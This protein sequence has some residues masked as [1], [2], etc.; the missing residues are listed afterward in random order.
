MI[1]NCNTV[2]NRINHMLNQCIK[3]F[4][5][6]FFIRLADV[7]SNSIFVSEITN[8]QSTKAFNRGITT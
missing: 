2:L 3:S 4:P 5:S 6:T 8:K 1:D 7:E